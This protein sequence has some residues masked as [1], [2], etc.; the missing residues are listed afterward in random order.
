MILH[1]FW[2]N[3]LKLSIRFQKYTI[4][5]VLS[6][7]PIFRLVPQLPTRGEKGI[8][9]QDKKKDAHWKKYAPKEEPI[10]KCVAKQI[11]LLPNFSSSFWGFVTLLSHPPGT[12]KDSDICDLSNISDI[13]ICIVG[14]GNIHIFK[15][16]AYLS[17]DLGE[18]YI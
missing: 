9:V 17:K 10:V 4:I 16:P 12:S 1:E 7:F 18:I 3:G 5:W 2:V 11:F 13:K 8:S 15:H 14:N 6:S